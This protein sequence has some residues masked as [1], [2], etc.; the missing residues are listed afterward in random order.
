MAAMYFAMVQN[1][2]L[3]LVL[4]ASENVGNRTKTDLI[5]LIALN[6]G[7]VGKILML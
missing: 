3:F 2:K 5:A 4:F 7:N 1:S 6:T